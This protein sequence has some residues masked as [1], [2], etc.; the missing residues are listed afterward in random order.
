MVIDDGA[1]GFRHSS[2]TSELPKSKCCILKTNQPLLDGYLW[3]TL[4]NRERIN[5]LITL[6]SVEELREY[7]IKISKGVSWEQ[8]CL[9]LCYE[10][11]HHSLLKHLI[12]CKILVV[13]MGAAGAVVIKNGSK[14]KVAEFALSYDP[15][16]LEG[17]WEASKSADA[18]GRMSAFT[19]GFTN[20][21]IDKDLRNLEK[22]TI[23]DVIECAKNGINY[24]RKMMQLKTGWPVPA[25]ETDPKAVSGINLDSLNE[26]TFSDAFIPSPYW[27]RPRSEYIKESCWSIFYDNYD[28]KLKPA[29]PIQ[30]F[31]E[32]VVL[33][34]A[35]W[36]TRKGLQTLKHVPYLKYRN[37]FTIDGMRLKA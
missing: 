6:I 10:L 1:L 11:V 25:D 19:A 18:I 14:K 33:L 12:K 30:K 16:F 17:E 23:G 26:Y 7:D 24:L 13:S 8:T 36:V 31:T 35:S 20:N 15:R 9:D 5:R 22:L 32:N 34:A 29:D 28:R 27:Y 3:K 4:M 21:L 2:V 37:L